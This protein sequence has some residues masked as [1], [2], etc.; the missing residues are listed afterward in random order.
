[1]WLNEV[2]SSKRDVDQKMCEL[3]EDDYTLY[4]V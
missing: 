1:M 2:G 4:E 3:T